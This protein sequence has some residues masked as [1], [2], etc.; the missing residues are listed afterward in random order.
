M[1]VQ[2]LECR[3]SASESQIVRG[4]TLTGGYGLVKS[5]VESVLVVSISI[6][7]NAE[8]VLSVEWKMLS[9]ADELSKADMICL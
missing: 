4:L 3:V 7:S 6:Y 1:E 2:R 8:P 5:I 9:R